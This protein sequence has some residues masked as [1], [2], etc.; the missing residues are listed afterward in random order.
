MSIT[1]AGIGCALWDAAIIISRCFEYYGNRDTTREGEPTNCWEN[2]RMIELGAGVGLPGIVCS[3]YAKR[4]VLT[5]C[6][7]KLIDNLN[8]NVRLNSDE[9]NSMNP[10]LAR[11][12]KQ[13]ARV[14]ML[15]WHDIVDAKSDSTGGSREED[16]DDDA[17]TYEVV[18]GSELVYTGDAEHIECLIRVVD[19][20]LQPDGV[21]YSIQSTDRDGMAVFVEQ[22][23]EN[24]FEVVDLPVPDRFL[25]N[26]GTKQLPE[27]YKFYTVWRSGHP[28]R[29]PI[30]GTEAD[31]QQQ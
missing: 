9:D 1:E 31:D 8:Y 12:V 19:H 16:D 28:L 25:G 4:C 17:H 10:E 2:V 29:Y 18:F 20:V 14:A 30:F 24:G 6:I 27:T 11:R 22:L 15:D 21:F 23:K 26:Y 13:A 7:P 3:R 5:D